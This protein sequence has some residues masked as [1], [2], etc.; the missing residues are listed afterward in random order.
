[1]SFTSVRSPTPV[2]G[3][4]R[5][6][7]PRKT[8][9]AE[10]KRL[11]LNRQRLAEASMAAMPA[12][13][14]KEQRCNVHGPRGSG[15]SGLLAWFDERYASE[16]PPPSRRDRCDRLGSALTVNACIWTPRSSAC[17]TL[18]EQFA[19]LQASSAWSRQDRVRRQRP[20]RKRP[21]PSTETPSTRC[22]I[23]HVA[24]WPGD[25]VGLRTTP[26]SV[27][28]PPRATSGSH[29]AAAHGSRHVARFRPR[30]RREVRALAHRDLEEITHLGKPPGFEAIVSQG[31]SRRGYSSRGHPH[32]A[33]LRG[34]IDLNGGTS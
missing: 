28:R 3:A 32:F 16:L 1:M 18:R 8:L 2:V 12:E 23:A 20:V 7:P 24:R 15:R 5:L 26:E 25:R 31:S 33:R 19:S 30:T 9:F 29:A 4:G 14:T 27:G 11:A 21:S 13:N 10:D 34:V 22:S 6:V 17:R